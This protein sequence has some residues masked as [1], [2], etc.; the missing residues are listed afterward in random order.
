MVEFDAENGN[1]RLEL[2]DMNGKTVAIIME[3]RWGKNV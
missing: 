2:I 1:I 3:G